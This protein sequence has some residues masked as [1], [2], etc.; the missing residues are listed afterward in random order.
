MASV[1]KKGKVWYYRF[2]DADGVRHELPGC[3]DKRETEAMLADALAEKSRIRNGYI[4]GKDAGYRLHESRPLADHINAWQANLV[5]EGS[6]A[7]HAEH[8]SNRVRRLVA[9]MLGAKEALNDHRRLLPKDRSEVARKIA[10]AIGPAR[11]SSLTR[12]KVQ[13]AIARFKTAGWSL[14]ALSAKE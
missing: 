2:T 14:L 1:R 12:D 4:D 11:L 13:D 6:S 9:M 3:T 5:S 10:S 7:K 8:A